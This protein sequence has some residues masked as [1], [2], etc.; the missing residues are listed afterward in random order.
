M[1]HLLRLQLKE[2]RTYLS[3]GARTP[4]RT[5][6][7]PSRSSRIPSRS[8][9]IPSRKSVVGPGWNRNRAGPS[10]TL[11]RTG[12]ESLGIYIES[13]SNRCLKRPA[14]NRQTRRFDSL[15]RIEPDRIVCGAGCCDVRSGIYGAAQSD[16]VRLSGGRG[17]GRAR[18]TGS[19]T[20]P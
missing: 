17:R 8:S 6:R 14:S 18:Q 9:R 16:K 20:D 5:S 4:S 2:V 12:I 15:N 10:P 11:S 3:R 13:Q 7:T 1:K 19:S